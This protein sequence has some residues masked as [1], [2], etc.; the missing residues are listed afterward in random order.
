[1]ILAIS[2]S[3]SGENIYRS[4]VLLE[5]CYHFRCLHVFYSKQ[6]YIYKVVSYSVNFKAPR[7][8]WYPL[9][10]TIR[11]KFHGSAGGSIRNCLQVRANFHRSRAW[12][13]VLILTLSSVRVPVPQMEGFYTI[14][15]YLFFFPQLT[16]HDPRPRPSQEYDPYRGVTDSRRS[17]SRYK[18]NI[19]HAASI[20]DNK[21]DGYFNWLRPSDA[22][23]RR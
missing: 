8:L 22:Y 9:S 14:T 20:W 3:K 10:K 2:A 12:Q 1:M 23:M 19:R 4:D 17:L 18:F 7:E 5:L 11:G 15:L 16:A 13:I 6:N 21:A